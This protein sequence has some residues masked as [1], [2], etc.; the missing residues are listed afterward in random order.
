[1]LEHMISLSIEE[2]ANSYTDVWLAKQ[3]LILLALL[4]SVGDKVLYNLKL[5]DE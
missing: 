3:Q 4:N 2:V 5:Y 1:M